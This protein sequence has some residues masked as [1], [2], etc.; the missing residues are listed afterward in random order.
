MFDFSYLVL[1]Y[2]HD[3]LILFLL[4][5]FTPFHNKQKG[6]PTSCITYWNPFL[7]IF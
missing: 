6:T 2:L 1:K 7:L 4:F 5:P 3:I